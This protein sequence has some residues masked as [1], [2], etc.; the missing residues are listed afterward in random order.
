MQQQQQQQQQSIL[1]K[2][3]R[4]KNPNWWEADQFHIYRHDQV[5]EL[6]STE[7]QKIQQIRVLRGKPHCSSRAL[8]TQCNVC[9]DCCM[10]QIA[11]D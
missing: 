1:I 10:L 7:K 5:A 3:N 6:G 2:R 8:F 4:L 11:Y 9:L